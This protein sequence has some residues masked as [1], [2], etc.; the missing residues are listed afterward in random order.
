MH[1]LHTPGKL[2]HTLR[3]PLFWCSKIKWKLS[4]RPTE[5][6]IDLTYAYVKSGGKLGA[7]HPWSWPDIAKH[8]RSYT[9]SKIPLTLKS[10]ELLLSIIRSNPTGLIP[11]LN[12]TIVEL[13]SESP[14]S[15]HTLWLN[16]L[17]ACSNESSYEVLYNAVVRGLFANQTL[18]QHG[19][20]SFVAAIPCVN[21]SQTLK[22]VE[23]LLDLAKER[24]LS[25]SRTQAM[26]SA[27]WLVHPKT[28]F[29]HLVSYLPEFSKF[30]NDA[31]YIEHVRRKWVELLPFMES[32]ENK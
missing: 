11:K 14:S 31:A 2:A 13:L 20:L 8:V 22:T 29:E 19:I 5:S 30:P 28:P 21:M 26:L 32:P 3:L 15:I 17:A 16:E 4:T 12:D 24:Q 9:C 10:H 18:R 25:T 7:L 6:V 1:F 23:M 27:F